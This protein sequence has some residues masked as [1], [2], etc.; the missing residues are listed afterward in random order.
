MTV[1]PFWKVGQIWVGRL[2]VAGLDELLE[3]VQSRLHIRLVAAVGEGRGE[4]GEVALRRAA[5]I[6]DADAVGVVG[7]E[8]IRERAGNGID[9]IGV[10]QEDEVAVVLDGPETIG[11]LRPVG[12]LVPG[13]VLEWRETPSWIAVGANW[14]PMSPISAIG[15]SAS[16]R[17]LAIS[18]ADERSASSCS[19]M[20]YFAMNVS[21]I[22]PRFAQ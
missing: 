11:V 14:I 16:A 18:C 13:V 22:S 20:L 5:W 9:E 15:F 19:A 3:V 6:V 12:D 21:H 7:L 4:D 10:D 1:S 8:Q 2:E 17:N